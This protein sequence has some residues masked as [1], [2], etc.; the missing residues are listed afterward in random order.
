MKEQSQF[1]KVNWNGACEMLLLNPSLY[2]GYLT[3]LKALPKYNNRDVLLMDST[4]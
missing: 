2:V 3:T 4:S 1:E